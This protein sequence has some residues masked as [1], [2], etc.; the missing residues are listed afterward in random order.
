MCTH[1]HTPPQTPARTPNTSQD[2]KPS[3]AHGESTQEPG[4]SPCT[5]QPYPGHHAGPLHS[6]SPPVH[7]WNT[8]YPPKPTHTHTRASTR[9]APAARTGTR[10]PHRAPLTPLQPRRPSRRRSGFKPRRPPAPPMGAP[11][12]RPAANQRPPLGRRGRGQ[13]HRPAGRARVQTAGGRGCARPPPGGLCAR[14]RPLP[15]SGPGGEDGGG[16]GE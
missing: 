12:A 3:S 16:A 8:R 2:P 11:H 6:R 9:R 13:S 1:T 5:H 10:G 15:P 7:P 4:H 14:H